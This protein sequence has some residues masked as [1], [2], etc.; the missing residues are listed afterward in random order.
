MAD[1]TTYGTPAAAYNLS[2]FSIQNGHI[3]LTA[4]S[5]I[6]VSGI[7]TKGDFR[8]LDVRA[9]IQNDISKRHRGIV[10]NG[11]SGNMIYKVSVSDALIG[12]Q[13]N[14]IY[15]G[16]DVDILQYNATR[17]L[18]ALDIKG[19][20]ARI[21]DVDINNC[22]TAIQLE[23][24]TRSTRL[25]RTKLYINTNGVYAINCV[26]NVIELYQPNIYNNFYGIYGFNSQFSAICG[27]I[28]NNASSVQSN[29]FYLGANAFLKQKSNLILDPVMR[30][31]SGRVEMSN[32]RSVS[33]RQDKASV[34]PYLDQSGSSLLT[35]I[36]FSIVGT[37]DVNPNIPVININ[38][39]NNLWGYTGGVSRSPIV[40]VDYDVKY[41]SNQFGNVNAT[42]GDNSPIS[43]FTACGAGGSG[44][45]GGE[46]R[47]RGWV[48]GEVTPIRELPNKTTSDGRMLKETIQEGYSQFFDIA[49]NHPLAVNNL[50]IALNSDFTHEELAEWSIA[51]PQINSQLIEA[52]GE[53]IAEGNIEKF[54]ADNVT[55]SELV[56]GVI[57]LQDKLFNDFANDSQ[58]L[59]TISIAK[60]S[61]FRMLDNRDA[62]IQVLTNI[63]NGLQPNLNNIKESFLCMTIK[64]KLLLEGSIS[65]YEYDSLYNCSNFENFDEL[66]PPFVDEDGEGELSRAANQSVFSNNPISI[67]PNPTNGLFTMKFK[68]EEATKYQIEIIDIMGT[69]IGSYKNIFLRENK[70]EF[71]LSLQASGIYFIRMTSGKDVHVSKLILTNNK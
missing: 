15:G 39:Q 12:I 32:T 36:D 3:V 22:R 17:C 1:L 11:Q 6:V 38:A 27:V 53:G 33:V 24:M 28:K 71:D 68:G 43:Q 13:S 61:L 60:A 56:Q 59:F 18:T 46:D 21:Q 63:S 9:A 55:Y 57:N 40:L 41:F 70:L 50:T 49:P 14:N 16:S 48:S 42:Y 29:G 69:K 8:S 52:L 58:N 65:P 2:L 35:D 44:S 47:M 23:G 54:N 31:G 51:I 30:I 66:P 25:Y 10:L 62:C 26:N 5:R 20:G 67:Y 34:G 4:G 45:S 64:E 19:A 7:Q 37:L